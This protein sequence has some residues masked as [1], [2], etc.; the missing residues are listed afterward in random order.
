MSENIMELLEEYEGLL[1]MDGYDDCIIGVCTR[2]GQEPIIAY[3]YG[4][5]IQKTMND[6]DM[7]EEEAIEFFEFN[8]IGSWVGETTPCFIIT[9]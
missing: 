3:D 6:S 9:E 1:K 5:V 4:K 7:T 2:F 8:Q